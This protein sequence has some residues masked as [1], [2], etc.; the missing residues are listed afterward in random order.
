M[1]SQLLEGQ[2]LTCGG[3][4]QTSKATLKAGQGHLGEL[5]SKALHWRQHRAGDDAVNATMTPRGR[6]SDLEQKVMKGMTNKY[7]RV[8]HALICMR[9]VACSVSG[10]LHCYSDNKLLGLEENPLQ[11]IFTVSS[12]DRSTVQR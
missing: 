9:E 10:V 7:T 11:V 5:V 4:H 3:D 2:L 8:F 12:Y 6:C 1:G